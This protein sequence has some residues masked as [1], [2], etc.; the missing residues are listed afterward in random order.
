MKRLALV[1]IVGFTF[2][3]TGC[4]GNADKII[5]VWTVEKFKKDGKEDAKDKNE[6][7]SATIEF[8]KDGKVIFKVMEGDKEQFKKET[9]YNVEVD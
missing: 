6:K 2:A 9:T 3:L 5:G 1:L 8:T 7:S 4:G